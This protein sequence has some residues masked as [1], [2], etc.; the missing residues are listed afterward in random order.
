MHTKLQLKAFL[1]HQNL[2]YN[3][4]GNTLPAVISFMLPLS[5]Y[6]NI[7]S[8]SYFLN[9]PLFNYKVIFKYSYFIIPRILLCSLCHSPHYLTD[10]V[11]W[12]FSFIS[13]SA[14][15]FCKSQC[16]QLPFSSSFPRQRN[17]LITA[18]L[19]SHFS[20]SFVFFLQALISRAQQKPPRERHHSR[21]YNALLLPPQLHKCSS[22]TMSARVSFHLSSLFS[23]L[24]IHLFSSPVLIF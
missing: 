18:T 4:Y 9:V 16:I 12:R 20:P 13:E 17:G 11:F 15:F 21:P 23:M 6:Y 24:P 10:S 7:G 5:N 2:I 8:E 1:L 14:I 22:L 19:Q 3:L